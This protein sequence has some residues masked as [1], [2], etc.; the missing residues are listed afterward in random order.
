LAKPQNTK[1]E[2]EFES[3]VL[4]YKDG[5][6]DPFRGIRIRDS[7][8]HDSATIVREIKNVTKQAQ[9]SCEFR[10][11]QIICEVTHSLITGESVEFETWISFDEE[12]FAT[13]YLSYTLTP[14]QIVQSCTSFYKDKMLSEHKHFYK[15]NSAEEGS[16]RLLNTPL[17]ENS[18][19]LR[20]GRFSGVESVTIDGYRNPRPPGGGKKWG[21]TRNLAE[22]NYPMGWI[23][24]T[25]CD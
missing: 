24:A 23:K 19:F 6:S 18:F 22:G 16:T 8:L 2:Y 9:G 1:E 20:I 13:R 3:K 5:K 4:G 10:S 7:L 14:E 15:K 21:T 25:F 12:L 17:G 11:M